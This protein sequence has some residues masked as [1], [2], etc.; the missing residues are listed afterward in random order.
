M[1][2]EYGGPFRNWSL[3]VTPVG[4]A[5]APVTGSRTASRAAG[6]GADAAGNSDDSDTDDEEAGYETWPAALMYARQV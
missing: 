6:Q 4:G 3:Y 5:T 1:M 2:W